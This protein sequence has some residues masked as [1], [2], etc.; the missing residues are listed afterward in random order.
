MSCTELRPPGA[1]PG[2]EEGQLLASAE[3]CLCHPGGLP[4]CSGSS[5]VSMVLG[6]SPHFTDQETEVV[7][8]DVLL[9]KAS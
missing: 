5:V 6:S 4:R 8:W 2:Q 3:P 1:V 7:L 9:E